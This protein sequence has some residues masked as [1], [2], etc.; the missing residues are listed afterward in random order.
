MVAD[1]G[2]IP[3]APTASSPETEIP[4]AGFDAGGDAAPVAIET[5][6]A[7][8]KF[9]AAAAARAKSDGLVGLA[10]GV[11]HKG[12]V[13]FVKGYG[14]EDREAS[15]PV[16]PNATQFRWASVSKTATG[17]LLAQLSSQGTINVDSN[18]T[19][20]YPTYVPPTVS[21]E[22]DNPDITLP[23]NKRVVTSRQLVG[24]LG[25]IAHYSNGQGT[26]NPPTAFLTDPTKNTGMESALVYLVDK[27][28]VYTPGNVMSYSTFG[29]NLLGVVLEKASKQSFDA[30]VDARIN[31]KAGTNI[32]I[33]HE[34][35]PIARRAVGYYGSGSMAKRQGS[36]DVSW[37]AGG[38]GLISTVKDF[39]Q[40]CGALEDERLLTAKEKAVTWA[41]QKTASGKSVHYGWGMVI[42]EDASG[43][44]VSHDGSQEKSRT[45]LSLH[46]KQEL[47][48]V[49]MTNSE[50]ADARA[51][52]DVLD[53]LAL[54]AIK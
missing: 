1:A 6:A 53:P 46:P 17:V 49:L 41:M 34:F 40:Y 22:G 48:V 2:P 5:P 19:T 51:I 27:P 13:I 42:G 37:K 44:V 16:D 24:H 14:F 12:K 54:D 3:T 50:Y 15:I 32:V 25:G 36:T 4:D 43:L 10:V 11:A 18:I 38:G 29:F 23:A 52:G 28:F 8:K 47:C 21:L 26:P 9:D 39:A 20:Y 30:L 45:L 7:W 33:D 35:K 31:K